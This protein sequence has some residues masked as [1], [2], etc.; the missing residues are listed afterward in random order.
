MLSNI[1]DIPALFECDEKN[2]KN[3]DKNA[4]NI[5]KIDVKN[6]LNRFKISY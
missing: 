3:F 4:K 5:L 6:K 2:Y 1:K